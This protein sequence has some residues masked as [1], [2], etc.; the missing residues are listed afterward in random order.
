LVEGRSDVELLAFGYAVVQIEGFLQVIDGYAGL[1]QIG[2]S[3]SQIAIPHRK[4]GVE[5]DGALEVQK[6][7]DIARVPRHA[8]GEG[9]EGLQ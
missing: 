1:I 8:D 5:F 9:L 4:V 3:D 6:G 7:F 2:V